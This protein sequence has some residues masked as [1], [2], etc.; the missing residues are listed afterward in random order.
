MCSNAIEEQIYLQKVQVYSRNIEF[1]TS[2]LIVLGTGGR[3]TIVNKVSH[4]LSKIL[5]F[6]RNTD[7]IKVMQY[8]KWTLSTLCGL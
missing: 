1:T 7:V 3:Y 6:M 2:I 8:V 5:Q 4:L